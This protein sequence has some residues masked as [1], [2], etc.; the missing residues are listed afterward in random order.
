[1]IIT[2]A[3]DMGAMKKMVLGISIC[4]PSSNKLKV[5]YVTIFH[6]TPT[7]LPKASNAQAVIAKYPLAWD[8]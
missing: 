5:P 2:L 8:V 1:M 7:T 3:Q 4:P 6:L